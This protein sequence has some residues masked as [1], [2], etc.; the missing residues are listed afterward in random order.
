VLC[1]N[2]AIFLIIGTDYKGTTL[3][4]ALVGVWCL[5]FGCLSLSMIRTRPGPSLPKGASYIKMSIQTSFHTLS[6]TYRNLPQM[7]KF[8]TAYFIYS[9][10]KCPLH[11]SFP[12]PLFFFNI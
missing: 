10:G 4:I 3:N 11:F 7:T 5:L 1:I 9:D 12:R 6:V 8:L 2:F